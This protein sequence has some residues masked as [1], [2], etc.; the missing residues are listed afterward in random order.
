M[1]EASESEQLRRRKQVQGKLG[2]LL[3]YCWGQQT[4][5]MSLLSE[6]VVASST[7][8][9]SMSPISSGI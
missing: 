5:Q 4:R 1:L 8:F 7:D 9:T 2:H 3:E 6:A